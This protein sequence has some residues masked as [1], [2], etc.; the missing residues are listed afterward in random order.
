MALATHNPEHHG[1][2]QVLQ[3]RIAQL[4]RDVEE[5]QSRTI[6]MLDPKH[7]EFVSATDQV[8][9]NATLKKLA[10]EL[11]R[12]S[13][14]LGD[15]EAAGVAGGVDRHSLALP[16]AELPQAMPPQERQEQVSRLQALLAATAT[17]STMLQV[18]RHFDDLD[19]FTSSGHYCNAADMSMDIAQSLQEVSERDFGL[20]QAMLKAATM[21]HY[22]RR[23][24]LTKRL[25]DALCNLCS[26]GDNLAIAWYGES[27]GTENLPQVWQA[28]HTLGLRDRRVEQLAEQAR[29]LVLEPLLEAARIL[30]RGRKLEAS[31]LPQ[32]RNTIWTWVD[33]A[34]EAGEAEN[35]PPSNTP[36]NGK[37]L[38]ARPVMVVLPALDSLLNFAF[39]YWAGGTHEV[40]RLLGKRLWPR[41]THML[42]THF[43]T[44]STDGGEALEKLEIDMFGKGFISNKENTLS[45][46]VQDHRHAIGQQRRSSKLAEVRACLLKEDL[47][48]MRVCDADEPTYVTQILQR[49]GKE[50]S[51]PRAQCDDISLAAQ[52]PGDA[53]AL[54]QSRE[55]VTYQ[56]FL[57]LP[58]MHVSKSAHQIAQ[59][60]R[61]LTAE[62][63]DAIVNERFEAATDLN[64]L[65]RELCTLFSCLRPHVQKTQLRTNP[66]CC[67]V[68]LTDCN[69][70]VHTLLLVPYACGKHLASQ[71]QH[72]SSFADLVPS[73]RRL[74]E[75]HFLA[76]LQYQKERLTSAL[77]PC[78]LSA[79]IA[80]DRVFIAAEGAIGAAMQEVQ[81]VTQ[82]MS[83]A[84]PIETL[85]ETTSRLLGIVSSNLLHKIY[86]L[87]SMD[88]EELTCV[89]MLAKAVSSMGHQI[90]VAL[91]LSSSS[92]NNLAKPNRAK[93]VPG[94]C[95]VELVAELLGADFKRFCELRTAI[96]RSLKKE[97]VLKLMRLSFRDDIISPHDAWSA[98]NGTCA[99]SA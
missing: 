53:A 40:S 3:G 92:G 77:E 97:E 38:E 61:I 48:L 64:K 46:H 89:T 25:E 91:G 79:G 44:C 81:S 93:D 82:A 59:D 42:I 13:A 20:E 45:R 65:V 21:A 73:L 36:D 34:Q 85:R 80:N 19:K 5:A 62:M 95:E 7:T 9:L 37:K 26:F 94:W 22:Q 1:G 32:A 50:P 84:L 23:A 58:V 52:A 98:L 99:V 56:G 27:H 69:Y 30:P 29:Q 41:I 39:D 90:F 55:D 88:P 2:L 54:R 83:A 67:A 35:R 28:L 12:T 33:T 66:Q 74:G 96:L 60:I 75:N 87:Q 6:A 49:K 51:Y 11:R 17:M 86:Q 4:G 76:M 18:Q 16:G 70:L 24:I 63:A 68:F 43:D 71:W 78:D 57:R 72:L 14:L 31:K 8:G 47:S 10:V 15:V